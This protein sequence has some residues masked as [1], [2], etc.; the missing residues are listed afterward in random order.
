MQG[1]KRNKKPIYNIYVRNIILYYITCF[2]DIFID[3]FICI[4]VYIALSLWKFYS[5][6]FINLMQKMKYKKYEK[7]NIIYN[8]IYANLF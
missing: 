5:Q 7:N 6:I 8:I 4:Y 2:R 3:L 1:K